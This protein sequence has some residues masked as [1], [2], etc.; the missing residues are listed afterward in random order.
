[1]QT[2]IRHVTLGAEVDDRLIWHLLTNRAQDRESTYARV[3]DA[4]RKVRI[5]RHDRKYVKIYLLRGQIT[6]P[7]SSKTKIASCAENPDE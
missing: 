4:G 7:L 3:K 6:L 1:V 2:A 5:K